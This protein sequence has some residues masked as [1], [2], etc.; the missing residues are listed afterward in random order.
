MQISLVFSKH[1]IKTC[2]EIAFTFK[3][4]SENLGPQENNLKVIVLT[5]CSQ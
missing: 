3:F 5:L 1:P 4:Q 2:H